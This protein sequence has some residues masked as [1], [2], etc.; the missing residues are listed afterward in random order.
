MR[1]SADVCVS[2]TFMLHFK[3]FTEL[4]IH[5]LL[6][7]DVMP[8]DIQTFDHALVCQFE[9]Q[10]LL[11]PGDYNSMLKRADGLSFE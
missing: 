8:T 1:K 3:L 5:L 10:R 4:Q 9:R 6:I 11:M 2:R 7:F